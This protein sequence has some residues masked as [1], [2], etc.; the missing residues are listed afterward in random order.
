ML[1]RHIKEKVSAVQASKSIVPPG[2]AQHPGGYVK[3]TEKK[4]KGQPFIR[5]T[6]VFYALSQ[7]QKRIHQTMNKKYKQQPAVAT[8]VKWHQMELTKKIRNC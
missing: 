6:I 5:C 2:K 3:N 4:E 7:K 8:K 1:K